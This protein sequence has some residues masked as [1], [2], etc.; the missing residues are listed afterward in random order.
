MGASFGCFNPSIRTE[1]GVYVEEMMS[2]RPYLI[3]PDFNVES[4]ASD[5]F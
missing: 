2:D 1:E 3:I 5:S 4:V